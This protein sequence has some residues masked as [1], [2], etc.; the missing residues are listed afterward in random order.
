M[1]TQGP[2]AAQIRAAISLLNWENKDLAAACGVTDQSIS[3]IKRG[4]TR[5]QPKILANIQNVLERNGIEFTENSGVRFKSDNVTVFDGPE[6]FDAFTVFLYEHL[7]V[8]GGDV[9]LSAED[10]WLFAKYRKDPD[11]HRK[12]M[13]ELYDQGII[14]SFRILADKSN[15]TNKY[16]YSTYKWQPHAS[17][18]PTAFYCFGDCLALISFVHNP[19]PYVVVLQSEP[20]AAS[21]RHAFEIAWS[22]A[23][24]PPASMIAKE[25]PL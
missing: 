23:K 12:R 24:D 11:L 10:E 4:I 13:K 7:K 6:K 21:Y 5:P 20:I 1:S 14:K 16:G 25:P 8:R 19:P 2:N 18:S 9:C 15:F 3:N 22:V 17:L